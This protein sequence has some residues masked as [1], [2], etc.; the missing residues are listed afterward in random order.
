M[1]EV[2]R[3]LNKKAEPQ[4]GSAAVFNF[5]FNYWEAIPFRSVGYGMGCLY[6]EALPLSYFAADVVVDAGVAAVDVIA[7]NRKGQ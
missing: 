6:F 4:R 5:R 3:L 7:K 2:S 1:G